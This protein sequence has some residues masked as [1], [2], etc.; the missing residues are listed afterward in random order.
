M[1]GNRDRPV[2]T[3]DGTN[4]NPA[5]SGDRKRKWGHSRGFQLLR[6]FWQQWLILS[7]EVK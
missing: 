2:L 6:D 4:S 5:D 3:K 7:L 1:E